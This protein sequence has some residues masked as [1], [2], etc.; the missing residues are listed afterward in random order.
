MKHE[1]LELQFND[2]T[3]RSTQFV[4]RGI[5]PAAKRNPVLAVAVVFSLL[6]AIYWLLIASD[7]YVSEAH[8]IV[9]RTELTSTA[10]GDLAGLLTGISSVNRG[11][12]L[13][14]RDYLQ[15]MDMVK[16]LDVELNLRGHYSDWGIDPISRLESD[17][18]LEELH[19]YYLSRV[20]IEF[21]DYTGVLIIRAEGFDPVTAQQLTRTLVREGEKFMNAMAHSL[22]RDQVRFLERQVAQLNDRAID[23]RRAVLN[24]Q[25][26]HGLVSPEAATETISVIVAKLEAQRTELQT[27]LR[28]LQ[29]YLV[30]DHPNIVELEQQIDAVNRQMEEETGKLTSPRGGK[31]NTQLEEFQRLQ[32][33]AE[34]A[35]DLYKSA[36]IALE[37]G[38]VE[39]TRT[40]KKMSVVQSANLPEYAEKPSRWYNTLLYIILAMLVAGVVHLLMAIVKDHRD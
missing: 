1:I 21:D 4:K 36:L 7:R 33:E 27:Q 2:L 39:G 31:L 3:A 16:K 23:A 24:Y 6:S 15:S 29:S 32:M 22:A 20:S 9:Q 19:R 13:I 5:W 10:P 25:N 35:Q 14:L 18:T 37:K 40:I 12:Q 8:V 38:R 11:D 28:S 17:P 26:K 30:P 34:F